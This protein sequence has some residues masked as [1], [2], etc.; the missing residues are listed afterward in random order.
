MNE[1]WQDVRLTIQ[2]P[3]PV[4]SNG[5]CANYMPRND[6]KGARLSRGIYCYC[7]F[8]VCWVCGSVIWCLFLFANLWWS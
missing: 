2:R 3:G 5:P 6:Y 4:D 1:D 8:R 7:N